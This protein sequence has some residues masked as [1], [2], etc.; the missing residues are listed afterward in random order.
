M[1]SKV[2]C[3]FHETPLLQYLLYSEKLLESCDCYQFVKVKYFNEHPE[4]YC[5]L[6]VFHQN[7]RRFTCVFL[8]YSKVAS[9][10]KN[11]SLLCF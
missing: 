8:N 11:L 5:S 10:K 1:D 3:T 6:N 4:E 2:S 7:I 9:R